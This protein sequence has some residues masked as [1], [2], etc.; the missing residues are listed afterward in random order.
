MAFADSPLVSSTSSPVA[1]SRRPRWWWLWLLPLLPCVRPL[2]GAYVGPGLPLAVRWSWVAYGVV[3]LVAIGW[4]YTRLDVADYD[5]D[6]L[7]RFTQTGTERLALGTFYKLRQ[8]SNYWWLH[9]HDE[10][11][12]Q[13]KLL[14]YPLGNGDNSS[15]HGFIDAIRQHNPHLE[16]KH[17]WL[18]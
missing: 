5:A 18:F 4:A 6:Y 11:N 16:A 15:I 3:A 8:E 14:I 17:A 13:K 2:T 12:R 7:Y 10:Q 1:L 9:Y